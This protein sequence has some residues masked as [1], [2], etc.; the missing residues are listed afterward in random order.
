VAGFESEIWK[1]V[2]ELVSNASNE[3]GDIWSIAYFLEES[4]ERYTERLYNLTLNAP[5][6]R[7]VPAR[8]PLP[9]R[10]FSTPQKS[11]PRAGQ[12]TLCR[13]DVGWR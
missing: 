10:A 12:H 5:T 3:E 11:P 1:A 8:T 6:S 13:I 9:P 4:L 2:W 7:A